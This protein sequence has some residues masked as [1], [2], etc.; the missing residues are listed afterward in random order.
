MAYLKVI[1]YATSASVSAGFIVMSFLVVLVVHHGKTQVLKVFAKN[2]KS[3][4]NH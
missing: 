2:L 1:K 3:N 4:V